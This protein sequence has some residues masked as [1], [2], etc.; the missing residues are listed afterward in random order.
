MRAHGAQG[1]GERLARAGD[2]LAGRVLADVQQGAELAQRQTLLEAQQQDETLVWGQRAERV[3]HIGA[4]DRRIRRPRAGERVVVAD[5]VATRPATQLV[6]RQVR[7][8]AMQPGAQ[9][10]GRQVAWRSAPRAHERVLA[11]VLRQRRVTDDPRQAR[12]HPGGGIDEVLV[13]GR[14]AHRDDRRRANRTQLSACVST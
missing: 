12:C 2:T 8:R 14:H 9:S 6:E 1:V 5:L 10:L 13:E 11:E 3:A 4:R 7:G